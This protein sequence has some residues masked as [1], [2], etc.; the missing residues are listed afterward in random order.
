[1]TRDPAITSRIMAAVRNRDTGPELMLRRE[2]HRRGLRYRLRTDLP[3]S[4]DLVFPRHRV[5]V[6][7]D[8]DYW[9]GNTWRLRGAASFDA[10]FAG[11]ANGNFWREK[12]GR[13]IR[14]DREIDRHLTEIGWTVIRIWESDLY[15]DL[16]A[17]AD[18]VE[19][20]VLA[21]RQATAGRTA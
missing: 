18:N 4:P 16:A 15:R 5:A 1:M 12:I 6:F 7:V 21:R 9:H 2:L 11:R 3:G 10:Y 13:N 20:T 17:C 14:R 8:G 19:N